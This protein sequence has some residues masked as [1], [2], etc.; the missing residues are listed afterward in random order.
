MREDS[1]K[2]LD[3]EAKEEAAGRRIR[4]KSSITTTYLKCDRRIPHHSSEPTQSFI[5]KSQDGEEG[6]QVGRNVGNQAYGGRSS[7]GSS[8]QNVLLI[9]VCG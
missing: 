5:Y 7:G 8:F 2:P 6:N 3:R 1:K 9:S 4:Y